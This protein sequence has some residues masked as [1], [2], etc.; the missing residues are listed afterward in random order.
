M[1][2]QR[3]PT[4]DLAL[5]NAAEGLHILLLRGLDGDE[6]CARPADGFAKA[7]GIIG[8]VFLELHIRPDKLETHEIRRIAK[9]SQLT[10]PAVAPPEASRPM[11]QGGHC[12]INGRTRLRGKRKCASDG[13]L[14][15][16]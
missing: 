1:I 12:A 16:G 7:R 10:D 11:R 9:L 5:A 13:G 2:H 14:H 8:V 15:A 4:L 6:P 3:G